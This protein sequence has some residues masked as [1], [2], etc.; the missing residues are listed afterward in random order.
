V[1]GGGPDVPVAGAVPLV[2]G[3]SVVTVTAGGQVKRTDADEFLSSRQRSIQA[4]GVKAGDRVVTVLLCREGDHLMLAN[5]A[6]YVTR[7]PVDDV[8]TMGRTAAGVSG[9]NLPKGAQIVSATTVAPDDEGEVITVGVDGNVKRT[10]LAEYST[11][12]RGGKGLQTGV[13]ALLYC[14]AARDLHVHADK[15]AVVRPVDAPQARRTGRGV[16]LDADVSAPVV[17]EEDVA[18]WRDQ[19]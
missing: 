5:S 9:M 7:F 18:R 15:P 17:V 3:T 14:G 2:E 4:T 16:V 10:A 1:V 12:G 11:Q 6:G 8:R 19:G 13:D